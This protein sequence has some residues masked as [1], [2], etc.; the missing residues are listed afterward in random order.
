MVYNTLISLLRT[1]GIPVVACAWTGIGSILLRYGVTVHNLFKLPVPIL[2]TS[3]CNV[4][5]VSYY[6]DYL[7]SLVLLLID[8]ASMIPNHALHAINRLLQD[9]MGNNLPFGG[10]I[11][12]FGGDFRQ[13][14]P[15]VPRGTPTAILEQCLK[16]SP[17]WQYVTVFKLTENMR[18]HQEEK[19]FAKWLLKLGNGELKSE[20]SDASDQSIDIPDLDIAD[21]IFPDFS[22][23]RT[24]SVIL[25]QKN[26]ISLKL[27]DEILKR[28]P[29]QEHVFFSYDNTLCDNE[30]ESQNYPSEFLN[31]I[32]PTGMP[33]HKLILKVGA[34]VMQ[35][36]N[37]DSKRGL[38]NGV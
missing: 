1:K 9:I 4:S 30:E 20:S 35:L 38:C 19:E 31:S 32:T 23:D 8:E 11:V 2:E 5:P 28:M 37:L 12:L 13:V 15:I 22:E 27:N 7:R 3:T 21:A 17:L 14:L 10:K 24:Y 6:T 34:T 33:P 16:R 18:A 26:E 25:T 29:G 36:R